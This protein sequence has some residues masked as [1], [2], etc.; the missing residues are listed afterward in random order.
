MVN[1]WK[2]A[3]VLDMFKA[4]FVDPTVKRYED[5]KKEFDEHNFQGE[6]HKERSKKKLQIWEGQMINI[7]KVYNAFKELILQHEAQTD[8]LTEIYQKWYIKVAY[9]GIQPAEMMGSQAA[10][11]Q[12]I[13]QRIYDV[14]EPLNLEIYPPETIK[15][16]K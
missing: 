9:E 11:V 15:Y 6:G 5:A 14:I 7:T 12:E 2:G 13:F 8:M 4:N 3:P 10:I 1:N 16:N